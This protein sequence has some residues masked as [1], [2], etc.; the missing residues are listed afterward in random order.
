MPHAH[1]NCI[2]AC[3][4]KSRKNLHNM[5]SM[6]GN[7][8]ALSKSLIVPPIM[9]SNLHCVRFQTNESTVFMS[10]PPYTQTAP[11]TGFLKNDL[12]DTIHRSVI[13]SVHNLK[14]TGYSVQKITQMYTCRIGYT[15]AI[16][17]V[18]VRHDER[19]GSQILSLGGE[20]NH[21]GVMI[22][23]WWG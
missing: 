10:D 13:C 21:W 7:V 23:W 20:C 5:N 14:L 22:Q 2:A 4:T 16:C 6:N 17:K 11:Q 15:H 1:T 8:S 12:H 19:E 18:N 3:F 9:S